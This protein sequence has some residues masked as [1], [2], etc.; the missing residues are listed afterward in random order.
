MGSQ[1]A[2]R[3]RLAVSRFRRHRRSAGI[4]IL[5]TV[6]LVVVL[7]AFASLAVDIGRVRLAATEVQVAA[8]AAARAA[9]DSLPITLDKTV[10]NASD[11][12]LANGVID[13]DESNSTA[14]G[15]RINPG[16]ELDP[17]DDIEFGVW[18][19]LATGEK[20]TPLGNG[21][22]PFKTSNDPR[23]R[24]NAVQVGAR[25]IQDR[26]SAIPLIFAQILPGGPD[27]SDITRWA[28]AYVSGGPS[29]FAFVGID[30]V[31]SNGNGAT[32]DSMV[33]GKNGTGGGVGSDGTIDLGNGDVYGDAR[34]GMT[35]NPPLQQG[36]NSDVTG[37]TNPL[38]YNLASRY[39]PVPPSEYANAIP[40][41]PNPPTKNGPLTL[42]G[43][44]TAATA[45]KYICTK[46]DHPSPMTANGYIILYVNGDVDVQGCQL[47]SSGSPPVPAKVQIRVIGAHTVDLGGNSTQ[48]CQIYAPQSNVK[49]HGT[50]GFYG[51]IVGK[52]LSFIG[53]S[54][55][56]YDEDHKD[57]TGYTI[58]LVK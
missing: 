52:T 10:Q 55:L 30:W 38:D 21:G 9:A 56:H 47:I 58:S 25:R 23:R 27:H 39:P 50:P 19:P 54:N 35:A 29:N 31:K 5:Y 28:T 41:N 12:A 43:G 57:H 22:D 14:N 32:I 46:L 17:T 1:Q 53:T 40:T 37:W 24:A 8:D 26:D 36:P 20:W 42:A 48:Y 44:A 3:R 18:S 49:V 7:A 16:V 4:S 51:Q 45:K 6:G 13:E 2:S 11:T 34:G 15:A 33:Y